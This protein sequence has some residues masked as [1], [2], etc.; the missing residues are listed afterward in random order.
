MVTDPQLKPK[1]LTLLWANTSIY[2][3][4]PFLTWSCRA[5]R[6][7]LTAGNRS[8]SAEKRCGSSVSTPFTPMVSTFRKGMTNF[9]FFI[10]IF[11]FFPPFFFPHRNY[12]HLFYIYFSI[13]STF[14]LFVSLFVSFVL[15]P[16]SDSLLFIIISS[17]INS[18]YL[19]S[20][21]ISFVWSQGQRLTLLFLSSSFVFISHLTNFLSYSVFM[22]VA[23]LFPCHFAFEK[24]S[25][26]KT[27]NIYFA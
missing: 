18:W 3:I 14:V 19:Y 1:S 12:L 23:C 9:P 17:S 6:R 26:R 20:H 27:I 21:L 8:V 2:L 5:L 11:I 24:G 15:H 25:K 22:F 7:M 4:T 16:L 13:C 10:F